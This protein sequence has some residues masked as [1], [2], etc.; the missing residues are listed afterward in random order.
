MHFRS[1]ISGLAEDVEQ[2]V[3]ISN[4]PEDECRE[5]LKYKAEM[6]SA[7]LFIHSNGF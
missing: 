5:H 7:V 4:K 1:F 3:Q 2:I 6:V